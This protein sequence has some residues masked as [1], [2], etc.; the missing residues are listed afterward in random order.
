MIMRAANVCHTAVLECWY[1]LH[2]RAQQVLGLVVGFGVCQ[3][4]FSFVVIFLFCITVNLS[5]KEREAENSMQVENS[6]NNDWIPTQVHPPGTDLHTE[7][8]EKGG[9][10]T[11]SSVRTQVTLSQLNAVI[12][13]KNTVGQALCI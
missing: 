9:G 4:S 8:A 13:P 2:A 3:D 11:H 5:G 10:N 7:P 6:L 1:G 12:V